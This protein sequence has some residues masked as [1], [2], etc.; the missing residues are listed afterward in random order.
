M[1]S[2]LLATADAADVVIW[3]PVL[4]RQVLWFDNKEG[5]I[6][7]LAFSPDGKRL[8]TFVAGAVR[9]WDTAKGGQ[10]LAL[11]NVERP[12]TVENSWGKRSPRNCLTF[13]PD[14]ARLAVFGTGGAKV[15]DVVKRPEV[16]Q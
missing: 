4:A 9:I 7:A 1:D 6:T 16:S 15:W 8:A 10:L 14:G 12:A 3:D 13:S 2:K 5:P 11:G